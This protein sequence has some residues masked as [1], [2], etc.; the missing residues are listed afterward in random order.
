MLYLKAG[1]GTEEDH[2]P[3][4]APGDLTVKTVEEED[5]AQWRKDG[6]RYYERQGNKIA[7]SKF[8]LPGKIA[9]M[10]NHT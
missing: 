9:R 2:M 4:H 7:S 8:I 6:I 10:T 1:H 3:K 5:M